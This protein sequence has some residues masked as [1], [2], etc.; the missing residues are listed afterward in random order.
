MQI[1]T[2]R[3]RKLASENE[4]LD[5]RTPLE[6][7]NVTIEPDY[8]PT[9]A[10]GSAKVS[11]G[12]TQVIVGVSTDLEEPFP[13]M[14]GKG[15][16]V[17]NAE[18]APMAD[19][20][21]ESGPPQEEGVELARVVDRGIREAEAIDLEDL[22]IEEGEKVITLFIDIHVLNNDGNLLD[23][24]ALGAVTALKSG[25]LP[26]YDEEKDQLDREG[27]RRPIP[28][29][30]T[31][32]TATGRKIGDT[33]MFDTT[34]QE[35]EAQDARLTVSVTEKGNVVAMQKGGTEPYS[36]EEVMDTV[37]KVKDKTEEFRQLIEDAVGE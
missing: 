6:Y 25:T 26:K 23:A 20:E 1:N 11:I 31:P 22:C 29:T 5:G 12:D 14:P 13:D 24:A 32:V 33:I 37:E 4:R 2:R 7:R 17:T 36:Q 16:I 9:T 3:I 21:F 15:T 28:L 27:E 10:D 8:I 19:R 34:K 30:K 18:L 35:E